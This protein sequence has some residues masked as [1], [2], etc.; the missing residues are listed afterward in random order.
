MAV[1]GQ[2][3][4]NHPTSGNTI[5]TTRSLNGNVVTTPMWINSFAT[6]LNMQ[7][8]VAQ[9][10]DGLSYRPIRVAERFL[11]FS[12]L[13]NVLDRPKYVR[14]IKTLREHW[15]YNL[16]ELK[17]TPMKLTYFGAN[18]TWLGFIENASIGY[19]VTDVILQY[20]FQMRIVPTQTQQISQ[21]IGSPV[22]FAPTSQD[23][24]SF[25]QAWYTIGEFIAQNVGVG[26]ETSKGAAQSTPGKSKPLSPGG[27][28]K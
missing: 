4:T 17:L 18:K 19:A 6:D 15:A 10:R 11:V 3:E 14:F 16:N 23:A 20:Q 26:N 12:T 9:L 13:W 5:L 2:G 27:P 7:I 28:K 21:V 22:P 24:K 1:I 25:G 8:D